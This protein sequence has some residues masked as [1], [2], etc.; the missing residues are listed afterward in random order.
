MPLSDEERKRKKRD[1]MRKW[2]ADNPDRARET[3][4]RN[5]NVRYQKMSVKDRGKIKKNVKEWTEK[6]PEKRAKILTRYREKN[7]EEIRERNR[8]WEE[9]NKEKLRKKRKKFRE[10]HPERVK[11]R[12]KRYQAKHS[13]K[14]K[15]RARKRRETNL[16]EF[17][18]RETNYRETHRE[19][20][21]E[22]Q[23]K[24][25]EANHEKIIS[26]SRRYR[27]EHPE[28][29]KEYYQKNIERIKE[30]QKKWAEKNPELVKSY[31]K[32]Y[33]KKNPPAQLPSMTEYKKTHRKCEWQ[34]PIHAG[35]LHVHHILSKHKY[36]EYMDGDYHGR[37]AN[38]FICFCSFHHFAY[39]NAY[40]TTKNDKKHEKSRRLLW[41]QVLQWAYSK[42]ISIE[43][44]QDEVERMLPSKVI[45]A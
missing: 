1:Y 41:G 13:E 26:W 17:R 34:K 43:D 32:R 24:W 6:N 25:R 37:I 18:K 31:K 11:A 14:I 30:K 45:L 27:R 2:R 9:K 19:R 8:K 15:K 40:A 42:K 4:R 3:S 16:E 20:I 33:Q 10:E 22:T 21:K 5:Q 44:L 12:Q 38:N 7:R 28:S 39:H 35:T 23:D 29:D 36:P